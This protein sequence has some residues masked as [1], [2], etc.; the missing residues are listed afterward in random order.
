MSR[1]I[2]LLE[3]GKWLKNLVDWLQ[4][5]MRKEVRGGHR[6]NRRPHDRRPVQL[7]LRS[8]WLLNCLFQTHFD[9]D[10]ILDRFR[11][12]LRGGIFFIHM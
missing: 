8:F 12:F 6:F 4:L 2:N 5:L 7:V 9:E 10:N 11:Q 1:P 3:Y